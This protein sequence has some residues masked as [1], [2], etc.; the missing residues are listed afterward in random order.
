MVSLG[1]SSKTKIRDV[2]LR[3]PNRTGLG[4]E[5]LFRIAFRRSAF[6]IEILLENN[7]H[8]VISSLSNFHG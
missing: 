7:E 6:I 5:F 1:N 8:S 2:V 4:I 3:K